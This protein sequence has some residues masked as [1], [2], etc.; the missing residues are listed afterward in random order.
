MKRFTVSNIAWETDGKKVKLPASATVVCKK[1]EDITDLL[2]DH[3]GWLINDLV[4]ERE[5]T[6]NGAD[7]LEQ[8][9]LWVANHCH[10]PAMEKTLFSAIAA[11]RQPVPDDVKRDSDRWRALLSCARIRIMGWAGFYDDSP[12]RARE[13]NYRYFGAEF[14]TQH[15]DGNEPS[16]AADTLI[17]FADA[18]IVN[19]ESRNAD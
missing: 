11:L 14:W 15:D 1:E 13:P 6:A 10:E 8:A 5:E 9:E 4:I 19:Q 18:V 17:A 12:S 16:N 3:Y 2:S 7:E